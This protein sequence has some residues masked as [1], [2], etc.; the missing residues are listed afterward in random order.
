MKKHI[1]ILLQLCVFLSIG[2]SKEIKKDSI[3]DK[4]NYYF[5]LE[6]FDL[7]ALE[8]ER[9]IFYIDDSTDIDQL[10]LKKSY[11][12]KMAGNY[13][14]AIL[15]LSRINIRGISI[16]F[17]DTI[18]YEKALNYYLLEDFFNAES[19]LLQ[20][21][22]NGI[23]YSAYLFIL[24]LNEQRRW[25]EAKFVF[26]EYLTLYEQP[27]SFLEMYSF[28]EIDDSKKKRRAK[29]LSCF[30][31]GLGQ[32]SINKP[33]DGLMSFSLNG[34]SGYFVVSSFIGGYIVTGG[35]FA[36]PFF[37]RFYFGGIKNVDRILEAEASQLAHKR[38]YLLKNE[39]VKINMVVE[40]KLKKATV[41]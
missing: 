5:H 4:A 29:M 35:V 10:L 26:K 37:L 31:P 2:Y 17:R 14:Q 21:N 19:L 20:L 15:S 40:Q 6:Q 23:K 24:V 27:L 9:S 11:C 25:D 22:N 16:G 1:I 8:Y 38:N 33:K 41:K 39:I 34:L 3:F 18:S 13:Q 36:L 7:A 12:Y 28:V 30:L 32:L